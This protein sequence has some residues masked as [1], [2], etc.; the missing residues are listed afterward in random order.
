MGFCGFINEAAR[1]VRRFYLSDEQRPANSLLGITD[2]P[3]DSQQSPCDGK[4]LHVKKTMFT[5]KQYTNYGLGV[6]ERM[7][8]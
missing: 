6:S 7:A 8:N 3:H 5:L 4:Y 2:S 1:G